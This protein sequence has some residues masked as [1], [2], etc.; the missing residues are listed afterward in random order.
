MALSAITGSL[1]KKGDHMA[2]IPMAEVTMHVAPTI[3]ELVALLGPDTALP[4][5]KEEIGSMTTYALILNQE[6]YTL[7]EAHAGALFPH[8]GEMV[9]IVHTCEDCRAETIIRAG[10]TACSGCGKELQL[11]Q[12]A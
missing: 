2:A 1:S 5:M 7:V 8:K 9:E 11:I 12:I 3:A 10:V 6:Q 4:L